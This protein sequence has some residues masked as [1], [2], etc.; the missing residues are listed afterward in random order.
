MNELLLL[1]ERL[2]EENY[3][4]LCGQV[5]LHEIE[6]ESLGRRKIRWVEYC[7]GCPQRND[8]K[9]G[10]IEFSMP[11]PQFKEWVSKNS[12]APR[13]IDMN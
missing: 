2:V 6:F 3:C 11:L 9:T 5:T 7:T 8:G 1:T 13:Q 4:P 12:V 10:Y